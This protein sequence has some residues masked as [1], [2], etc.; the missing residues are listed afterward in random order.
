MDDFNEN[1]I[2]GSPVLSEHEG[3]PQDDIKTSDKYEPNEDERKLVAKITKLFEKA[4]KNRRK[5]DSKWM[6]YY[7]F[8][9]GKQ[10]KEERPAYR[11]SAVFNMIF[12]AIQSNVPIQTDSMPKFE[13][14][15]PEPGDREFTEILNE[16]CQADW[17][18]KNWLM[19]LTAMLYDDNIYGTSHGSMEVC[20]DPKFGLNEIEYE[21]LDPFYCFPDPNCFDVNDKR[22]EFFIY[23]EPMDVGA[24]KRDYPDK[25]SAI[26]A[27]LGEFVGSDKTQIQTDIMKA[28][29]ENLAYIEESGSGLSIE[30]DKALKITC[31]LYDDE[32]LEEEADKT[33]DDGSIVKEKTSR[34]KYPGGR[35]VIITNKIVLED[36]AN[37]Y[38]DGK[39]PVFKKQN[40]M[41]PREYWGISEI[42]NL[43]G[44]QAYYNKILSF[45]L[46]VLHL[47]GN[48]IWVVSTDSG[49]DTESIYNRPG[50]IIEKNP[51]SEVRREE[52][53][54]LQPYVLNL[55]EQIKNDFNE[56]SANQEVS[57]GIRPEGVTAAKAIEALQ[58]TAQTRMRLKAKVLDACLQTMGQMYFSRA[59]QFKTA[60]QVYRLTN[61]QN[62]TK[63][64][65]F[66]VTEE[67]D[68]EIGGAP[69]IGPDG[70][71]QMKKV[72]KY[73]ELGND[74]LTGATTFGD[75]MTMNVPT[76]VDIRVTT[77]STLSFAKQEKQ[78]NALQLFDRQALD[79]EELLKA[80]EWPN[81]QMVME[82]M[83]AKAMAD[84]QAQAM[85]QAQ[86]PMPGGDMS[87]MPM[88]QGPM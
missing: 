50:L 67:P 28:P 35:K 83:Q 62:V 46:D 43:E 59:M 39:I 2:A 30:S 40:Y 81:Y 74:P 58:Q 27:D 61:N 10:W 21:S 71:P 1:V 73:R 41:L 6:D 78:N 51:N 7:K 57:Q 19:Q 54:H 4:K 18:S 20:D 14:L 3:A 26:K 65:K 79:Q 88:G 33:L 55:A 64:F 11:H 75:E 5:Y 8:F 32:I 86:P 9:R 63:Y 25:A 17:E 85:A 16:V 42:E 82:R 36:E 13:Y 77:G 70:Q 22:C 53:V 84:A 38:E 68:V 45:A 76:K 23:A 49:V 60:P 48:P 69:V 12:R 87:G 29:T 34:K 72:A 56:L 52:G 44:P 15:P 24:L 80:F 37:E 31:W 66:H 47:T